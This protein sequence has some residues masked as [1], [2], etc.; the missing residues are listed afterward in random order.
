MPTIDRASLASPLRSPA[1]FVSAVR[2]LA[3]RYRLGRLLAGVTIVLV[4]ALRLQG[5]LDAAATER[6]RWAP[7]AIGWVTTT[8]IDAGA[9]LNAGMAIPVEVPAGLSPRGA[10]VDDPTGTRAR[11]D[12]VAGMIL[13]DNQ[14]IGESSAHTARTPPGSA[15]IALDRTSDLFVVG[16]RVDLHDLVDGR[17]LGTNGVV[18]A[19]TDGDIAVAIDAYA[20][21]DV[22]RGLGRGG[23]VPV[24]RAG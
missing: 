6:A 11:V 19:V 7:G 14:L 18:I 13:H 24:L 21:P 12:L 4:A 17:R 5:A 2:S 9:P 20:V 3:R 10:T 22:V 15:S 1:I 16:D 8:D 23:V